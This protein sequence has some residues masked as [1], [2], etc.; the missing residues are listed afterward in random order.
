MQVWSRYGNELESHI[1]LSVAQEYWIWITATTLCNGTHRPGLQCRPSYSV[2]GSWN[3]WKIRVEWRDTNTL[4]NNWSKTEPDFSKPNWAMTWQNQ[5]NEFAPSEDSNQ[6]GHL[7]SLI[8]VFAVRMT[9]AWI[10][11]Y[12]LNV[13]W[14]LWSDWTDAQADLSLC[15][16]HSQIVGFVMSRL[17]CV[18]VVVWANR[19]Q[20]NSI[21]SLFS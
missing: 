17:N 11:S 8:R 20:I 15:W 10:L 2:P 14:R 5:Q 3:D 13:Q 12:P 7:P 1:F 19:L 9:K 16:A 18:L 21:F 6:P 4:Y